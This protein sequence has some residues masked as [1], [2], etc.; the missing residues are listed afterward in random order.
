M[1]MRCHDTHLSDEELVLATDGELSPRHL[2]EANEHLAACWDCRAR[3]ARL[4]GTILNFAE[5]RHAA[6]DPQVPPEAARRALLK[7]HLSQLVAE[8]RPGFASRL[9][10]VLPAPRLA[11]LAATTALVL[12]FGAATIVYHSRSEITSRA[13]I[14]MQALAQPPLEPSPALTPGATRPV[15]LREV[16]SAGDDLDVPAIPASVQQAVFREYGMAGAS[17]KDYEVDFLITPQLGGS[18]DIHNLWPEAYA[19]PVWNAKVKDELEDR[20]RDMVCHGQLDLA[21]AQRD[22]SKDWIS[23]YKKYFHTDRPI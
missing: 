3:R 18:D 23:A 7:A 22:I 9:G 5:A 21:T 6:L 14:S 17:V 4:E 19:S 1:N 2:S 13:G 15:R 16:C 11:A 8:S 10:A 12:L 20:L